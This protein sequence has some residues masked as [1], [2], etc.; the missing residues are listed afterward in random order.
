MTHILEDNV[1]GGYVNRETSSLE[2]T[3]SH[4]PFV[5][6]HSVEIAVDGLAIPYQFKIWQNPSMPMC[7]LVRE[8]SEIVSR[9]KEGDVLNMR[10]YS[11]A[12]KYPTEHMET[13][14]LQ[15]EKNQEG[16]FKGHY[17]IALGIKANGKITP[18]DVIEPEVR[19]V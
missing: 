8:D 12:S 7:L 13:E 11:E 5:P 16:R 19:H 17:W 6:F 10:Y 14:I 15:I 18:M 4:P 9:L 2:K 1:M 3:C